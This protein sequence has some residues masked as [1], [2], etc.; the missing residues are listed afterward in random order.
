[1]YSLVVVDDED[2]SREN[3]VSCFPW[4]DVG[5][6]VEESFSR[7]KDALDYLLCN[8]VDVLMTDIRMPAM[9]G[10]ELI[11]CVR[12]AK[13]PVLPVVV[14]AYD[15]FGYAQKCISLQVVE[16]ILKPISTS[17]LF[18]VFSR[19]KARLDANDKE[20]LLPEELDKKIV[21]YISD[22]LDTVTFE[23]LVRHFSLNQYYLTSI[24]QSFHGKNYHE[25]VSLIRMEEAERL[26]DNTHLD[27]AD[28]SHRVGYANQSS[29]GRVFRE[30]HGMSPGEY[31]K[32]RN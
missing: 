6:Q 28:I 11:R 16:Y 3:I 15:D 25:Y 1:M 21:K 27:I 4:S 7:G 19:L 12:K 13:L 30:K 14:T 31:R 22:H 2:L 17:T 20:Q 24:F 29:F 8:H 18:D 5:F 32:R 26:L 10:I 9:D 23:N